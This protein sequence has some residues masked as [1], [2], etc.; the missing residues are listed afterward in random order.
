MVPNWASIQRIRAD[1]CKCLGLKVVN[2]TRPLGNPCFSLDIQEIAT[3]EL[4]N[5]LVWPHLIC[6]PESSDT[7]VVNRLSQSWKWRAG[8]SKDLR[9]QMIDFKK[10][11]YYI[12]EPT[13]LSDGH[14]VAPIF[15]FQNKRGL[16]AKCLSLHSSKDKDTGIITMRMKDEPAFESNEYDTIEVKYFANS[17]KD[18]TLLDGRMLHECC[19]MERGD[20]YQ[21]VELPNPW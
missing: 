8:L 6:V 7:G 10:I 13:Q 9:V 19:K 4:A 2:T 15:F 20:M 14:L 18:I 16:M 1:L 5:P 17:F 21:L 12:Y 3:Q 11:H